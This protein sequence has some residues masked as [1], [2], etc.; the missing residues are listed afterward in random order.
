MTGSD[1]AQTTRTTPREGAEEESPTEDP[2]AVDFFW[3]GEGQQVAAA[4]GKRPMCPQESD[5]KEPLEENLHDTY[6]HTYIHTHTH[7]YIRIYIYKYI[8]KLLLVYR[9]KNVYITH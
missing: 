2:V 6:I 9:A 5:G 7:T 8:C 3:P 4:A 1:Q